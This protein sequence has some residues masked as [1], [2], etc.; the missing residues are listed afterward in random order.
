MYWVSAASAFLT[1][2]GLSVIVHDGG[3]IVP[4]LFPAVHS[5]A[6]YSIAAAGLAT[7]GGVAAAG[8]WIWPLY[9]SLTRPQLLTYASVFAPPTLILTLTI[10]AA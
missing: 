6:G 1:L 4:G 3:S 2:W 7:K 8:W 5:Q 9:R 10:L